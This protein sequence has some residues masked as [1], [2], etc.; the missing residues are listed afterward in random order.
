MK[1]KKVIIYQ[2]LS[3]A[4]LVALICT[5]SAKTRLCTEKEVKEGQLTKMVTEVSKLTAALKEEKNDATTTATPKPA[6]A[7]ATAAP[8]VGWRTIAPG[9]IKDNSIELIANING[10]LAMGNK[11]EHNA[12]TIGWGTFGVLWRK[13]IYT[14]Y[15]SSSRFS[16]SLMEKNNMFT[17]S[18]FNK[19]HKDDVMYLGHHSGRDG[20]KISK[21]KFHLNYTEDGNPIFDEAFLVIECRKIY[22]APFDYEKIDKDCRKMYDGGR[23]GIHTEYVGEIVNVYVNDANR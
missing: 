19:S 15:V 17:I 6:P 22:S 18:F 20:D 2:L 14:V 8:Y 1:D 13:P 7:T 4:L 16:H 23:V 9:E 10:I 5:V 12:M 3:V 21:T 11:D